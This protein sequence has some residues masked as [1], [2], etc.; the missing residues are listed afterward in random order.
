MALAQAAQ[1]N[2]CACPIPFPSHPIPFKA[3]MRVGMY[4]LH[5]NS[6]SWSDCPDFFDI[7][8][9]LAILEFPGY[10]SVHTCYNLWVF[11]LTS[12]KCKQSR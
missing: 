9:T 6:H 10:F 2:K 7:S 4:S 8:V 5:G 1:R 11:L 3:S 12:F